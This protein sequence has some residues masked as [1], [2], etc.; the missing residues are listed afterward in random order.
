MEIKKILKIL[1]PIVVIGGIVIYY[2]RRTPYISIENVDWTN[3]TADI[4]FGYNSQT[5]SLS[6]NGSMNAGKTYSSN[7]YQLS[8]YSVGKQLNLEVK[9]GSNLIEKQTI[10]FKSKLIY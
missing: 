6:T 5:I 1:I 7:L 2:R 8:W 9:K 4:Q 3:N 10:D